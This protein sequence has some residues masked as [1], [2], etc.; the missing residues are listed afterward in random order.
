MRTTVVAMLH[1][2]NAAIDKMG[3]AAEAFLWPGMYLELE[4]KSENCP[5]CRAAGK[6]LRT[7]LPATEINRLEILTELN[8]EIQS[9][10]AGP[11][12][13]KTRGDVYIIVAVDRFIKWPTAQTCK[14][15]DIRTVIKFLTNYR[16]TTEHR[17]LS[18]PITAAVS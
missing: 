9:E 13:S 10:F 8:Q 6:N 14:N 5:S 17:G 11:I 7:Q 2:G 15:T 3:K 4:E 18:A 12:E 16:L 1:H